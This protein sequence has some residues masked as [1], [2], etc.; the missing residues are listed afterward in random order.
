M[1]PAELQILVVLHLNAKPKE[2]QTRPSQ[3]AVPNFAALFQS[4][5]QVKLPPLSEL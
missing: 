5:T 3:I 4:I 2:K 1:F